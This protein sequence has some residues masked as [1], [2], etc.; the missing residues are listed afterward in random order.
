MTARYSTPIVLE[1]EEL[2]FHCEASGVYAEDDTSV[3]EN[4]TF[5]DLKLVIEEVEARIGGSFFAVDTEEFKTYGTPAAMRRLK[6]HRDALDGEEERL[7]AIHLDTV[8]GKLLRDYQ[9]EVG[10]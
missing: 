3:G 6:N 5:E 1:T 4:A 9:R 8:I 7:L 10:L 2:V